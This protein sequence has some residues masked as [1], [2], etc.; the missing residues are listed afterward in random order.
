M[1]VLQ[2]ENNKKILKNNDARGKNVSF[3]Q[4]N[5]LLCHIQNARS[6]FQ[7]LQTATVCFRLV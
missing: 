4:E 7:H 5:E 2:K 3:Q 6:N 1:A